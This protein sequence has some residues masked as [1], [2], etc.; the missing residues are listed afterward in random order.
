MNRQAA[1]THVDRFLMLAGAAKFLRE[2][3]KRNRRRVLL[4]PA[5]KI[6]DPWIVCHLAETGRVPG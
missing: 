3:R 6:F 4:D 2:L 1:R 5:S